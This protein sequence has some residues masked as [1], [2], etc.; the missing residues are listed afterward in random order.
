LQQA[1]SAW[2]AW[3]AKEAQK[4][5]QTAEQRM[6]DLEVSLH[7]PKLEVRRFTPFSRKLADPRDWQ[8]LQANGITALKVGT[9]WKYHD[10]G[11]NKVVCLGGNSKQWQW[12]Y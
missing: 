6:Y 1:F 11:D 2:Q 10:S 7:A 4:G 8:Q 3:E 9:P 5:V 12:T